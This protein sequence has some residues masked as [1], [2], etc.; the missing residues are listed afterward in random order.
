MKY[1]LR[2]SLG[3]S[4]GF[5]FV[6][7]FDTFCG[8]NENISAEIF[9]WI[10]QIIWSRQFYWLYNLTKT[11]AISLSFY[12]ECEKFKKLTKASI[13]SIKFLHKNSTTKHRAMKSS[14]NPPFSTHQFTPFTNSGIQI[15]AN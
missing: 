2:N 12:L 6:F 14:T 5:N 13:I 3:S 1:G 10:F 15:T 8:K 7:S 9:K 4:R 11:E